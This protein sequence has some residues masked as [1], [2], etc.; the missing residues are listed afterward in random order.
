MGRQVCFEDSDLFYNCCERYL[1]KSVALQV[2]VC[3]RSIEKGCSVLGFGFRFASRSIE[4]GTF[5]LYRAQLR[6][7]PP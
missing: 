1:C 7:L 5:E 2:L 4:Q 6:V 3:Q